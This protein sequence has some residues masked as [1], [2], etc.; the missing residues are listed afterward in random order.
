M[1]VN[2]T[3]QRNHELLFPGHVSTLAG[4]D[5]ELIDVFDNFAFDEVLRESRLEPRTRLLLQLAALVA[6][7]ALAEY[8]V[9]LGAALTVGGTKSRLGVLVFWGVESRS[10][11]SPRVP[12]CHERR[13]HR[14]RDRGPAA[15]PG[16][17][18]RRNPL[19]RRPCRPEADRRC[20]RGG[21]DARRGAR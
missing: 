5:P 17:D 21:R 9:M 6:A 7:Q 4:T 13:P 3:A 20:R 15:G 19:R 1:A 8:R 2:E 12:P 14:A 16:D 18:D 11:W 10:G